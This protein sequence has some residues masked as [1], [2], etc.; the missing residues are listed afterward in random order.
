MA[1]V[2]RSDSAQ[3]EPPQFEDFARR[4]VAVSL[5]FGLI[6]IILFIII[7]I[8]YPITL[9]RGRAVEQ[10]VIVA[11]AYLALN[12]AFS[13]LL[14]LWGRRQ[15][16]ALGTTYSGLL[17]Q[18]LT[19]ELQAQQEELRMAN[20]ALEEQAMALADSQVSLE[21]QQSELEKSN[22]ALQE[23]HE[24]LQ[25]K[26]DQLVQ[27]Q[28]QLT[29]HAFE[30]EKASR[31]K[32]EFLANM[33]HELRTPLNSLLILSKLLAD[34]ESENLTSEQVEFAEAIHV[35]GNDLLALINDVLDISKVEAG[36]LTVAPE[37]VLVISMLDALVV[38]FRA[39]AAQKKLKF[40]L[41][42]DPDVPKLMQTDRRRIEQILRNLLTNAIKFT[43]RGSVLLRVTAQPP[44]CIS[45]AVVDTGIGVDSQLLPHLFEPF[46]Q[47][48]SSTSRK[49]GGAG[50]GL[51]ISRQLATLLG[52]RIDVNSEPTVGSVFTFTVPIK[53]QVGAR[54]IESSRTASSDTSLAPPPAVRKMSPAPCN[55]K[56]RLFLHEVEA[57]LSE[58]RRSMLRRARD[59]DYA[60]KG[61]KIL[62]V[63]D[64]VRNI[65]AMTSALE[66]RG[67]II[68]IARNGLDA[69]EK[70][71]AIAD[72][73]LILMDLMMPQ[74][75]GYQAMQAIRSNPRFSKLPIIAV[76]ARA[77]PDD[78]EICL[79]A[80]ASDYVE[81]PVGVDRLIALIRAWLPKIER[82]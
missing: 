51:S 78:R 63:D 57:D 14:A 59:R 6:S 25:E 1:E 37:Q 41:T 4:H 11:G 49:Y 50:L 72:I 56:V 67:A 35:A 40:E 8:N 24:V 34:N 47:G 12:L 31:Y 33:S 43:S 19:E 15:L 80:G 27:A 61:R 74:M 13:G 53:Y 82:T 75:D 3:I 45:F 10:V 52:G 62:L 20:E 39:Q 66:N 81:N 28:R 48:D 71:E 36:K 58:D 9:D 65:F 73:E 17:Q 77:M 42:V 29:A 2:P 55:D 54:L 70:I 18:G 26:N 22:A 79:R 30:L 76:S 16:L 64:D 21:S 44:D 32:S 69:L 23:Q 7:A 60:L 46:F 68:E 5:G 38:Q